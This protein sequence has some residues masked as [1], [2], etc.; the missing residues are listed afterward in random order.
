MMQSTD[1]FD[2]S[3]LA[4][5]KAGALDIAVC[6]LVILTG[7]LR[8]CYVNRFLVELLDYSPEDLV[9]HNALEFVE[10][11]KLVR[12]AARAVQ[13]DGRWDG[14]IR[15][16]RRD[17][18]MTLLAVAGLLLEGEDRSFIVGN[19]R[20]TKQMRRL[21]S[22][23]NRQEMA[24]NT[25]LST[26]REV[27]FC[28]WERLVPRTRP[29]TFISSGIED[30]LGV[31]PATVAADP[32]LWLQCLHPG[33]RQLATSRLEEALDRGIRDVFTYRLRN[34]RT[35]QYHWIEETVVPDSQGEPMFGPAGT[36][37]DITAFRTVDLQRVQLED[38]IVRAGRE[39]E[40]TFDSIDHPILLLE[41]GGRLRRVN[42][43]ALPALGA[44]D[45]GEVVGLRL[46]EIGHEPWATLA[47]MVP[48]ARPPEE[49]L[50]SNVVD[51]ET[52]RVWRSSLYSA[53]RTGS[54]ERPWLVLALRD[55]TYEEALEKSLRR[56]WEMAAVG[57]MVAGVAHEV[58]NPLFGISAVLDAL[59]EERGGDREITPFVSMLRQEV[60]RL[61]VLMEEL[62]D[63][64]RPVAE[65]REPGVLAVLLERVLETC[66]SLADQ[67]AVALE[68]VVPEDLPKVPMDSRSLEKAFKNL[69]ENA[70]QHSPRDSRVRV[71]AEAGQ[72]GVEVRV[73]DSGPGFDQAILN[74]VV[75]PFF[76]RRE[77]GTGLGLSIVQR[78]VD[79]H[80]ATLILDNQAS[81]GRATILFPAAPPANHRAGA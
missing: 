75:E 61:G 19:L 39:W 15:V 74:R 27:V 29:D 44:M 37:R 14:E 5:L 22:R 69:V 55:I 68:S 81:G 36:L 9:G 41:A 53:R 49:G 11:D 45:F 21:Q 35:G 70:I 57:E 59:H 64:G 4:S 71:E 72:Q 79:G 66:R 6:P 40:M 47:R 51:S 13:R 24:L 38:Q 26:V 50:H 65:H 20:D 42:R 8:V 2:S 18:T 62:L 78:V 32:G 77:G 33:D 43:C 23:L 48:D 34:L 80:R 30:I 67:R 10:D 76:S 52:G 46:E 58:R 60:Q 56:A 12:R 16:R 3:Y 28:H 63:Y 1:E 73:L 31:S 17:G 25:I 54:W 7:E